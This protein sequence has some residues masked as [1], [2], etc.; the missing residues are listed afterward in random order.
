MLMLRYCLL[1]F[2]GIMIEARTRDK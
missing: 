2:T 1:V